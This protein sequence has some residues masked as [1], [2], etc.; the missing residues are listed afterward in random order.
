M[1]CRP[2]SYGGLGV[3]NTDKFARALRLRWLWFEWKEPSKLWVGLGNPCTEEDRDFFYAST[4]IIVGN[5]A[6]TPFW[7]S[8][9]LLGRKP[10]DIAPLVF[11]A[12][13]RKNWKVREA[14]TQNAW[15]L[16][17][18]RDITITGQHVREFF[19]LWMLIHDI[20][21]DIHSE[22]DIIWKHSS[23]GS[24]SAS[25][26]YNAQFLGLTLSPMDSMVWKMWAPPKVKFF[27]WLALQD[28]I[29]TADRLERRG[30]DNCGLCP[31][32]NQVQE[33][34][35]HLFAKCRF[36]LRLWR[37]LIDKYGLAHLDP[38]D[39]HLEDSLLSWWDKRTNSSIPDRRA[40]ASLT[41]LVSWTI[42]NER[43]A[44]VFRHKETP[45]PILLKLI[46]DEANLWVT[47]GAKQLGKIV[48]RE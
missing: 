27:S 31:L 4:S 21:L 48:S 39:W 25:T 13:R 29:W 37:M 5:G 43:N 18:R 3:L 41:M 24:Y 14:I 40:M 2:T 12:S 44:R 10:K 35:V 38:S 7:D 17:I 28:R 36:T 6:R 19:I 26:A 34:G 47:A 33:S 32:C 45:P 9:W 46:I 30:W 23:D 16:T 20:H 8:P 11:E 42:W 15:M 22:D 1:V